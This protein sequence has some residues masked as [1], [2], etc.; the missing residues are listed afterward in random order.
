MAIQ[1]FSKAFNNRTK[2]LGSF[3]P[4]TL[5]SIGSLANSYRAN[6]QLAEAKQLHTRVSNLRQLILGANHPR[7]IVSLKHVEN[8]LASMEE[9]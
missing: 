6:G 8:I 7:T 5:R 3:H 1:L 2:A 9:S 4:D